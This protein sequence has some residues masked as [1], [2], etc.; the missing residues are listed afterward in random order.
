VAKGATL[1]V[2]G[3]AAD[4]AS[5]APVQSV[6]VFVDGSSAGTA[7]LGAA[8]SD[9]AQAFNRSDYTNSGWNFQMSTGALSVGSHSVT[10]T[11]AGSSGTGPLLRT[12]TVNIT[13]G[14][15]IGYVDMAGDV[16]GGAT[17]AQ[18]GTL[19]VRG[20]AAD[21]AS[22]A[23]VQSVTVL[24]DGSSVGTATL[25]AARPDVAQAFNR[26]DYANSGW[27]FQ[28]SAGTLTVGSH[29]VTATAAGSSGTGS[30]LRTKT[31]NI[32]P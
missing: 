7:T 2:R 26:S 4:T 24:V 19:Y 5:G 21:T 29:S 18:G 32:T 6:T 31:V 27:N 3:W 8:R 9:V 17:V 22:G 15:E 16:Q 20:W 25:G 30:L 23:P 10:A 28:M 13:A 14:Q 1:Y 11:A 12:K